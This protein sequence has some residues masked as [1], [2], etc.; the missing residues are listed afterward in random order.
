MRSYASKNAKPLTTVL[1]DYEKRIRY[2]FSP[3]NFTCRNETLEGEFPLFGVPTGAHFDGPVETLGAKLPGLGVT[4]A[5]YT[6]EENGFSYY[7]YHPLGQEGT[8]CIPITT[9]IATLMPPEDVIV[10]YANVTTE[11]PPDAFNL[12]PGC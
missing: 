8:E 7:T 5:H 9:S 3:L 12:P 6:F 1:E 11:L 10:Q 4:V 2:V